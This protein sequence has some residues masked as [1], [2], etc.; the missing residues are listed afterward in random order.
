MGNL[1]YFLVAVGDSRGALDDN[2]SSPEVGVAL[3]WF[4]LHG[5]LPAHSQPFIFTGKRM[6][7][8]AVLNQQHRFCQIAQA[9]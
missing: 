3:S 8:L 7:M 6:N 2:E 4:R 9:T 1:H 5:I